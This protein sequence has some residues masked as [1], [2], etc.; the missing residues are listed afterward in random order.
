MDVQLDPKTGRLPVDV[1]LHLHRLVGGDSVRERQVE[2]FILEHFKVN[3]LLRLPAVVA[4][5][6]IRRPADFLA[7]VAEHAEPGLKL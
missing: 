5:E 3:D 4:R 6:I 1:V 2:V 7:K